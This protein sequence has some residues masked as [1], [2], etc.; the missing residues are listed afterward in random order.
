VKAIK[1]ANRWNADEG[2]IIESR[3]GATLAVGYA[4]GSP[5]A[6]KDFNS[7][8]WTSFM[9]C[10][11]ALGKYLPPLIIFKGLTLQQQWFPV[12]LEDHEHWQFT[13]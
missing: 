13:A 3:S 9:E 8:A 5:L 11:N 1:P 10:V 4:E 12:A 6:Q 7:R 2:G